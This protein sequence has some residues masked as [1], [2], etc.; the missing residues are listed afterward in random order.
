MCQQVN[1]LCELLLYM[2]CAEYVCARCVLVWWMLVCID[3][4]A[5][6][7]GGALSLP[8]PVVF[9]AVLRPMEARVF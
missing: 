5:V 9:P 1:E 4:R 6:W 2:V 3:V 7:R 8:V